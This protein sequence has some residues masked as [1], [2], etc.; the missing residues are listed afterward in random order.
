MNEEKS[1]LRLLSSS[2]QPP[3][4][5]VLPEL[6]LCSYMASREIWQYADDCGVN[7]SAWSVA[8]AQKYHTYIGT[9]YLDKEA[10]NYFN[11]YMIAGSEVVICP[12][13]RVKDIRF[14][15]EDILPGNWLFKHL[16]LEHDTKAGILSYE[17]N[18]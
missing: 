3:D 8:M 12:K 4:L 9:G 10:G 14:H 13:R 7:T 5:D 16:I 17:T 2:F 6:A 1:I 18:R 15:R 11:R